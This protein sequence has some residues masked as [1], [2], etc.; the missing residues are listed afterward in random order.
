MTTMA[1]VDER[2]GRLIV[3]PLSELEN[4]WNAQDALHVLGD[5]VAAADLGLIV[6][7]VL[8]P[9]AVA[10]AGGRVEFGRASTGAGPHRRR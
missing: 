4:G 1:R 5:D 3:V 2:N 7:A 8:D 6:E 9:S 10:P